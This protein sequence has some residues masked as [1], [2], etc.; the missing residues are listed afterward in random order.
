VLQF[1]A[2]KELAPLHDVPK[3]RDPG[4]AAAEFAFVAALALSV[5]AAGYAEHLISSHHGHEELVADKHGHEMSRSQLGMHMVKDTLAFTA[6]WSILGFVKLTFWSATDGKGLLGQGD[7][8]TSHVVI[9]FISSVFSFA[10]FFI[11]DFGA[12]RLHGHL[13]KGLRAF[14]KAFM[15][16]LGLA[17]EGAFWEGAHALGQGM[18]LEN[19]TPRML[20]VA[21]LS[22]ALC[23]IVMPAWI[24]YIVP[25]TFQ[26]VGG[27]I[28]AQDFDE[29]ASPST[30]SRGMSMIMPK[31]ASMVT[32][33]G[34]EAAESG[35]SARS[36]P[37]LTADTGGKLADPT[38]IGVADPESSII[39]IDELRP[40]RENSI[41]SI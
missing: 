23:A 30:A 9:V 6:G 1:A 37:P 15:I 41:I 21:M 24:I 20:A 31:T 29:H 18:G 19:Q 22:L 2:A 32:M 36:T 17:W 5:I 12:D 3:G 16:L 10:M 27:E 34:E 14:G 33:C 25:H 40:A 35:C 7:V 38:K 28:Q 8:M 39:S 13:G 11:I 26:V 4:N